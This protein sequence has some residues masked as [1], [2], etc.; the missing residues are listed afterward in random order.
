MA[1]SA[2]RVEHVEKVSRI[3]LDRPPVNAVSLELLEELHEA[4]NVLEARDETRCIVLTGA[5]TKAFC[6][7]ADLSGKAT[8]PGSEGRFRDLGRTALDRLET[9]PKPVISAIRGWCIGGGFALGMAC[10]VRLASTTA[11]FRTG[12]AY[13][14]VV[15]AWG[16]SLSR[17]VHFIGRNRSLDMLILGEDLDAAGAKEMGLVKHSSLEVLEEEVVALQ[18][19]LHRHLHLQQKLRMIIG[20]CINQKPIMYTWL[21]CRLS[22][23]HDMN[24]ISEQGPIKQMPS[25]DRTHQIHNRGTC[26]RKLLHP[27]LLLE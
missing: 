7:G 9:I 12:D 8:E 4:L 22:I 27:W 17:L 13:I 6:A 5:G 21:Q 26:Q 1:Y 15:P 19:H 23:P 11:K 16:M 25:D 10:D 14:G 3:V 24:H 2:I 18:C 20:C